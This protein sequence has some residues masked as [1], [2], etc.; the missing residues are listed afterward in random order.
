MKGHGQLGRLWTGHVGGSVVRSGQQIN[1]RSL[2][3]Q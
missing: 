1:L 2:L 3:A